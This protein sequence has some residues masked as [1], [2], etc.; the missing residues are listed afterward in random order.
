[1]CP[2]LDIGSKGRS[3]YFFTR[4]VC[5]RKDM[6]KPPVIEVHYRNV[7]RKKGK[8]VVWQ[9]WLEVNG[10]AVTTYSNPYPT[11]AQALDWALQQIF[12]LTGQ[13]AGSVEWEEVEP[14]KPPVTWAGW[15]S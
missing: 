5:Y 4:A 12:Q 3:D 14:K 10:R 2:S 13:A 11:R 7:L 9:S 1:M 8:P 15:A 6:N